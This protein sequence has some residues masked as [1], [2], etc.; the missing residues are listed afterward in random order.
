M[1]EVEDS[2]IS[3]YDPPFHFGVICSVLAGNDRD[4]PVVVPKQSDFRMNRS[5]AIIEAAGN[6][7]KRF[8]ADAPDAVI[9]K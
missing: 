6:H 9:Y 8:R 3:K 5:A 1:I 4:F 7:L 2:R